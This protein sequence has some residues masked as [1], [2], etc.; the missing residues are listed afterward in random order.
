ISALQ[1]HPKGIIICDEDAAAELKYG[2]VK[3]FKDI[4]SANLNPASLLK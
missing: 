1:L 4:E 2:T 3:Y